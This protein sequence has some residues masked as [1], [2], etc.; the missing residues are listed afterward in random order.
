MGV[1]TMEADMRRTVLALSVVAVSLVGWLSL[2]V[3]A[4]QTKNARGTVTAMSADMVTVSVGGREMKFTIDG[5]TTVIATGGGT[6]TRKAEAAGTAGPKLS[7]LVKVGDAV[8]VDYHEMGATLHAATV[9]RVS[10]AG[11]GGGSTSDER[12][13]AKTETAMGTVDSITATSL[14]I[15]GSQSG[16]TFKQTFT[17]DAETKVVGEGAGTAAAAKGGRIAITDLLKPGDRVNVMYHKMGT[18][19]HAA[20]VRVTSKAK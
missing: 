1:S 13:A 16:G 18:T 19:L 4:Q 10:S 14:V 6:A 5:K 20:E 11:P 15:S 8:E 9:R 12:A 7:D 2:P 17:V 3:V